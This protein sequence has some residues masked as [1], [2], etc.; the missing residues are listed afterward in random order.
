MGNKQAMDMK[1]L[2]ELPKHIQTK[3][4]ST[5]HRLDMDGNGKIE[6]HEV[7]KKFETEPA[8]G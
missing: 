8:H 4:D 5:F 3:L 2:P 1:G 7:L 6:R